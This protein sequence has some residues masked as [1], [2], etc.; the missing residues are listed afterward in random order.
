M[1]DNRG[2]PFNQIVLEYL[3]D[4]KWQSLYCRSGKAV[5]IYRQ[6]GNYIQE[7]WELDFDAMTLPD[8]ESEELPI[9]KTKRL[10][11]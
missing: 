6:D 4:K 1:T 10:V 7:L 9:K 3:A 8:W 2:K 11:D 5:M